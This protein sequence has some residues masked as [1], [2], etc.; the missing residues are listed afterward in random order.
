MYLIVVGSV[1]TYGLLFTE[2]DEYYGVGSG[3]VAIIGSLLFL[4]MFTAGKILTVIAISA[5]IV[6]AH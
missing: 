1:K 4:L 2:I 3:P 6:A 5:D